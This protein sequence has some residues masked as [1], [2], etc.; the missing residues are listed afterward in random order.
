M[1]KSQPG[2]QILLLLALF[3]WPLLQALA[4]VTAVSHVSIV[5]KNMDRSVE[6]YSSALGFRKVSD[7]TFWGTEFDNL[8][9]LFGLNMRVVKMQ[10]GNET[11]ELV[12]YLTA[13]GRAIPEDSKANDRWFQHIAIVVSDME[14][15]FAQLKRFGVEYVSTLPQTI[16][17]SNI[18]AA[19]IKA[20][21]F[22]DPD[23]HTLE[24][25][26]FPKGKGDPRWQQQ[27]KGG[28]EKIFLGIDHT[29]IAV[30]NTTASLK[31]YRDLL[32]LELKGESFNY[33]IEQS[34]LNNVANDSLHISG[35]RAAAGPGVEFLEYLKPGPGRKYPADAR[36]DDLISW[37][38]VLVVS[39]T[40]SVYKKLKDSGYELV[41]HEPVSFNTPEF[42]YSSAFLVRDP[43]GH[44]VM[45]AQQKNRTDAAR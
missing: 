30:A 22:R 29:A 17:A 33:G 31:F 5:V 7:A 19:G 39:E 18:A 43:D 20:F 45:V 37:Q 11:V 44:L 35:L 15:A 2:F 14:K 36:A 21:Y 12:D 23:G 24:L 10:L 42:A 4:Q 27:P 41:S 25:I 16:P 9:G 34:R 40:Y 8:N 6:F 28:S 32:G 3:Q 26:Y 38:T 1:K 13:G